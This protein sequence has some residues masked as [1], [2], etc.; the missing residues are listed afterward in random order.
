[1]TQERHVTDSPA[2]SSGRGLGRRAV[3]RSAAALGA[4]APLIPATAT[5]TAATATAS[6]GEDEAGTAA[7][8]ASFRWLGTAGWRIDVGDRTVLFDPYLSRFT[9]GL[10]EGAFDPRTPLR[11]RPDLVDAHIGHPELVLV[12]HSHWDHLAD[13]PHIAKTTGARVVGTE[14]TYHLLVALGVDPGQISVV[15]GGEVLDFGGIVVEVV[16]S[17]HSRNKKCAYFAPGTLNA[18]PATVPSTIADLPEG[19]TLAFQVRAGEGGP[20]AFLMGASDFSERAVRGL[21][22]DLAMIAVP[23]STATHRYVPRLLRALDTPGVVVP[24]HWDNFE[25]PLDGSPVPDPAMD[26]DAFVSE[27]REVA[28]AARVVVPDY[29]TVYDGTMRSGAAR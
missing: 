18:P 2:E 6:A 15:K 16:P 3:L 5:A 23:A 12:S 28:P 9:T 1:M 19:D 25:R 26:L 13:V 11:T 10:Y 27:V 14:T 20:S 24:V 29:R 22:P 7:G 8:A 4:A 17:L 21:R